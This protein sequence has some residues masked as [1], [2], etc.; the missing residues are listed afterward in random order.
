MI[1]AYRP[2][3]Q[4]ANRFYSEINKEIEKSRSKYENLLLLGDFNETADETNTQDIHGGQWPK[5]SY[6]R[7]YML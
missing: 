2:L 5:K 3:S 7:L 1:G 4:C 6:K